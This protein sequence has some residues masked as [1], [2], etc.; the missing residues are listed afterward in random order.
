MS[1]DADLRAVV[2]KA[3]GQRIP[4]TVDEHEL[5]VRAVLGQQ[6]TVAAARTLGQRLVDAGLV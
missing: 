6:I 4:R 1:S 3:S 5:A 2:T